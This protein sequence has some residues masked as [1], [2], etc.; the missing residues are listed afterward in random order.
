LYAFLDDF[1]DV[2]KGQISLDDLRYKLTYKEAVMMRNI[3]V[4]RRNKNN[5]ALEDAL[6]NM[7]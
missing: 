4:E 1:L 7:T 6:S 3:R 5:D 2:F